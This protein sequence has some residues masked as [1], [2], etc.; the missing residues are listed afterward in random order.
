MDWQTYFSQLSDGEL[1]QHLI[2]LPA[3]D[4]PNPTPFVQLAMEIVAIT[5]ELTRRGVQIVGADGRPLN[6]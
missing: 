2:A 3:D 5:T 4:D 6:L 1:A